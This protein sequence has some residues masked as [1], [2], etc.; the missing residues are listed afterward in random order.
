MNPKE[1]AGLKC[2]DPEKII[3]ISRQSTEAFKTG[4]WSK[5]RPLFMEKTAPCRA[6]CPIGN[7]IPRAVYRASQGDYNRALSLFL[8]ETP[9]PGV[10]GRVCYH[11]CQGPCNRVE[12]DGAVQVRAIER[13]AAELGSAEPSLLTDAGRDRPVAVIGAGPAGLAAAYHLGRMGHPVSLIEAADRPGGLLARGIPPFRLPARELKKDLDRIL[14]LPVQLQLNKQVDETLLSRL[15]TDHQAVFLAMGAD[16]HQALGIQGE[17]LEGVVHGIS[18][19]RQA[20]L[21]AMARGADVAVIGGGNTAMDTART[22]LRSGAKTVTVL[23]RRGR[24][25]MPAFADEVIEAEE[26]GVTFRFLSGPIGFVGRDGGVKALRLIKTR[27]GTFGSDRRLRPE[28]I[29]G[30]EWELPCDL[31]ILGAGQVPEQAAMIRDLRW[32][33]G[34]VWIDETGRTSRNGLFAGGDLTPVRASVVDAMA[35][36]KRAAASIH[37][38]L[39]G[40]QDQDDILGITLGQ[41]PGFSI[42]ALFNPPP[43][44]KPEEVVGLDELDRLTAN[45]KP[46]VDLPHRPGAER[47]A[48]FDEVALSLNAEQADQEAGRCFFCGTCV[49]CDRCYVFCP[50]GAVIPPEEEGG[51]YRANDVFCKGCGTCSSG[52]IRGVLEIG[53]GR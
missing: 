12:V 33:G 21:Q 24:S 7:D 11:P 46:S 19:L 39:T 32:E 53:E 35:S 14:S 44:W 6:A 27:L 43:R 49:G 2:L 3:P 22:A 37:T 28:A 29:P 23:Y 51:A 15:I 9:L 52:C 31:V 20:E 16:S 5:V 8:Q 41:G 10:C 1:G 4:T 42:E 34:R 48:S 13:A 40:K 50:E 25:E 45:R 36:G 17:D 18:F 47:T 38:A 30:S 26:E